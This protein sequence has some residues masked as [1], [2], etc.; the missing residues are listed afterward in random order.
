VWVASCK[1]HHID[2]VRWVKS[3]HKIAFVPL[4]PYDVKGQPPI[5][6]K[7]VVFE[8]SGKSDIAVRAVKLEPNR[9]VEF[10][11]S[12]P[13]EYRVASMRPL[14]H[15]DSPHMEAHILANGIKG[16]EVS[17]AAIPIRFDPKSQSFTMPKQEVHGGKTTTVFAPI[18]NHTGSLQAR[19]ESFGGGSGF[20]GSAGS[21]GGYHGGGGGN[22]AGGAHGGSSGSSGSHG[23]GGSG[24]G[25]S[26]VSSASSASSSG[27]GAASSSGGGSH[28]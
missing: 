25:G 23:G 7:H 3:D 28:H 21:G 15:I 6:V 18:S 4:H 14:A 20:R 27:A 8:V 12:P 22:S 5:N 2:P 24:G 26:S 16:S 11:Q 17:R 9:P 13:K 10:L 19:G 1:R